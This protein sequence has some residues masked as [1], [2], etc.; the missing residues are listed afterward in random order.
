[1]SST[2]YEHKRLGYIIAELSLKGDPQALM[3]TQNQLK[4]V[5]LSDPRI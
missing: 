3:M 4:K 2:V 5:G 1:M